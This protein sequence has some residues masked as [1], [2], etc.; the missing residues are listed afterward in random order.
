MS[1]KKSIFFIIDIFYRTFKDRDIGIVC[2]GHTAQAT[3]LHADKAAGVIVDAGT[4]E[5][6]VGNNGNQYEENRQKGQ[7]KG[8]QRGFWRM[9]YFEWII[10]M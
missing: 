8:Q 3:T 7:Q 5:V 9:C 10:Q 6:D 4:G 1:E 2:A